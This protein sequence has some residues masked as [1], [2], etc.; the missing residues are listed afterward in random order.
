MRNGD[1]GASFRPVHFSPPPSHGKNIVSGRKR[2]PRKLPTKKVVKNQEVEERRSP[3]FQL[4]EQV[5]PS[6]SHSSSGPSYT[7]ANFQFPSKAADVERL[8][9]EIGQV[10]PL[11]S[12]NSGRRK[13][14]KE[15]IGNGVL[16]RIGRSMT[17]E[18]L[19]GVAGDQVTGCIGCALVEVNYLSLLFV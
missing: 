5:K 18:E 3:S 1:V 4:D 17:Y 12:I 14:L 9:D 6:A 7:R 8:V 19:N 2:P 11:S 16:S 10:P 15:L 13:F